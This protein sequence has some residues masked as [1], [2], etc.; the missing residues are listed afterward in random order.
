MAAQVAREQEEIERDQQRERA[1]HA[2]PPLS[3]DELPPAYQA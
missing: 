3:N 1:N 2:A